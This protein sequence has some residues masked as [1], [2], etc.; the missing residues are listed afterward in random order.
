MDYSIMYLCIGILTMM[1]SHHDTAD[2]CDGNNGIFVFFFIAWPIVLVVGLI[3]YICYSLASAYKIVCAFLTKNKRI[4]VKLREDIRQKG[5]ACDRCQGQH[6]AEVASKKDEILRLVSLR[7]RLD[8]AMSEIREQNKNQVVTIKA[9]GAKISE[10]EKRVNHLNGE[11]TLWNA[12][13]S[14]EK[15]KSEQLD[16]RVRE[17]VGNDAKNLKLYQKVSEE[18]K[19]KADAIAMFKELDASQKK[20]IDA[21]IKLDED[22]VKS[23]LELTEKEDKLCERNQELNESFINAQHKINLLQKQIEGGERQ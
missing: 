3:W 16:K 8:D 7:I 17:L 6:N 14:E 10:L 1:F 18:L 2:D 22:R 15:E 4:I 21:F 12:Y 23:I 9:R 19:N 13:Y 5:F 20:R 11:G